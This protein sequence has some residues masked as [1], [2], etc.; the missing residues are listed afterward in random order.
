MYNICK[1]T[2]SSEHFLSN[3]L[4]FFPLKKKPESQPAAGRRGASH[5]RPRQRS[6]APGLPDG[7]PAPQRGLD[8]RQALADRALE[9]M[10]REKKWGKSG[11]KTGGKTMVMLW[12]KWGSSGK[13]TKKIHFENWGALS[14]WKWDEA[15]SI[16]TWTIHLRKIFHFYP[17]RDPT[18]SNVQ[19]LLITMLITIIYSILTILLVKYIQLNITFRKV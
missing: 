4:F 2:V 15:A 11:G 16:W 5:L 18:W 19:Y 17:K 14:F 1:K 12:E 13:S 7:V 9:P 6:A 8:A 3:H 10:F